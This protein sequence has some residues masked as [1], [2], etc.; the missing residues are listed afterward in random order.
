M[1][2]IF[3]WLDRLGSIIESGQGNIELQLKRVSSPS[4]LDFD[5][6]PIELID[7]GQEA[8]S[9]GRVPSRLSVLAWPDEAGSGQTL[10]GQ[11]LAAQI[12]ALL[13]LT[14]NR[15]IEVAAGDVTLKMEGQSPTTFLPSMLVL[16]RSLSG[17]IGNDVR[18]AFE[19]LLSRL[20]G[21]SASDQ[22]VIGAAIELHYASAI[23]FDLEP[24]AA[25]ALAVAGIERL[26]QAYGS[27]ETQWSWWE[28]A[29]RLDAAFSAISLS[30][31]QRAALRT[32]LLKDKHLRLRQT[33]ASYVTGMLRDDF[34]TVEINDFVPGIVMASDGASS[35]AGMNALGSIPITNLVPAD[36]PTLRRRLLACYDSRSSYVHDGM[37]APAVTST[38]RQLVG[39][40]AKRTD[41]IE[42]AGVRVMLRYLIDLE[43][44]RRG[45]LRTLPDIR[46]QHANPQHD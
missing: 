26:S 3:E 27:S 7:S 16:D 34:W 12:G 36:E 14:T 1:R 19:G 8:A 17:P 4:P 43:V 30:E 38:S 10:Q 11:A 5:D 46:L 45:S 32:E 23:L 28:E 29:P 20:Y 24:N 2:E 18:G 22:D 37:G 39:Q 41:R 44:E 31:G 6:S 13:T 40:A 21:M 9:F 25:Y 15:R 33:F 35:F 42:Y